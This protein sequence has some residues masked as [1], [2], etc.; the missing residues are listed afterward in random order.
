[1]PKQLTAVASVGSVEY[2]GYRLE[3]WADLTVKVYDK[4]VEQVALPILKQLANQLGVSHF[5][6]KGGVHNTRQLGALV[7]KAAQGTLA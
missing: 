7:I 5:N 2:G 3:R 4:G 1:V 6:G